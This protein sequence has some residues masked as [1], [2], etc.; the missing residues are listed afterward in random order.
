PEFIE[1]CTADQKSEQELLDQWYSLAGTPGV[2][3]ASALLILEEHDF[4]EGE[5]VDGA[6]VGAIETVAQEWVACTNDGAVA[7]FYTLFTDDLAL[8]Q[9][10][11]TSLS[12]DDAEARLEMAPT[13]L[14][15]DSTWTIGPAEQARMLPDGRVGATFVLERGGVA[16]NIFIVFEQYDGRWQLDEIVR[17]AARNPSATVSSYRI[18]AEYPHEADAYTQGL[19]IVD[20]ELYEG[21][22]LEGR[23]SLRRVDLETGEVL[24]RQALDDEHFG[25]GVAVFGDRIYQLTWQTGTCFV[26]DRETFE[27][28]ETF[29]YETEGWGLTTDD[30]QLIMS[31]GSNRLVFRDPE[32]F[33]E[34][35]HVDVMDGDV[36]VPYLNELEYIDGEVWANVYT[37]DWIVRIDPVNGDVT[38]W[39]DLTGLLTLEDVSAPVDVL[40]GI[41]QDPDTGQVYVTGKLWPTLFEIELVSPR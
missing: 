13:P 38:G 21:T 26:Y 33:E 37:T 31:D 10:L 17:F 2:S 5:P 9:G 32:T 40:N 16:D 6:V 35:G 27:L 19:V 4:P 41:A 7:H 29:N 22:G 14:V 20:G 8:Q 34:T 23:S 30:T 1:G 12:R 18:V 28:E 25:E 36:P 3:S 15:P 24:Q 39:I 11:H